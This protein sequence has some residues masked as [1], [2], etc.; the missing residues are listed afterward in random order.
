MN[1]SFNVEIAAKYGMLEAVLIEHLH[2]WIAKNKA[3]N[4]NLYDG[5]FWTYC[6]TKALSELFPYVSQKTISRALH[7]LKEEGVIL[8]G[9]YNKNPYDRT[10]WYAFTDQGD[11]M[12]HNGDLHLSNCQMED[13]ETSNGIS[14]S[15][16]PIPD[17]SKDISKDN[18][19][20]SCAPEPHEKESGSE[21]ETPLAETVK[22]ETK[23][24]KE[25]QLK[26]DFEIIYKLYPK[27]IG[28]T[29]AFAN[30]KLWVSKKGKDVGGKRYRLS[31]RQIYMAVK[32]YV[33]Q[34]EQAGK[35]LEYWKNF[36][37]LMGR[38]LLDYVEME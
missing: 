21:R 22:E 31:N 6:S 5:R 26:H 15:G 16:A 17:I 13:T 29:I 27:K 8:F 2:F 37:T 23:E 28:K 14:E 9:N 19:I 4:V 33:R 38:Q 24:E 36:D 34:Q 25:E 30:Y 20:L 10:T 35:E 3:N 11:S 18:K 12:L 32:K 1:H 7:H